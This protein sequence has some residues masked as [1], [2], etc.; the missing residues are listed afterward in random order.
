VENGK[1]SVLAKVRTN[2]K[3]VLAMVD[4]MMKDVSQYGLGEIVIHHINC[5]Q[6]AKELAVLIKE[7]L[8]T[9]VDILDIGPVIGLHVGPGALG[10][11]YY[12]E[13]NMR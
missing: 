2:K 12:T 5:L 8:K 6:K 1:T 9:D 3:A 10:I 13:N 11:A 7:K 4:R